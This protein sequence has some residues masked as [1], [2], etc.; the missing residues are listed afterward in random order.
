M[1]AAD[2]DQ[3]A[4]A[5]ELRRAGHHREAAEAYRAALGTGE[6]PDADAALR[7]ARCLL[8]CDDTEGAWPWVRAAVRHDER[9]RTWQAAARLLPRI[10]ALTPPPARATVRLAVLGSY[11]TAQ[12]VPLLELAGRALGVAVEAYE[13]PYGQYRQE[14]LDPG[15]GLYRFQPDVVVL[16][17]HEGD[18]ELPALSEDPE[19]DVEAEAARWVGL[20]DTLREHTGA[21]LVHHLFARRTEGPLGH[22]AARTPGSRD[23]MLQALNARLGDAA[24]DAVRL[25]DCDRLAADLGKR[26]WFDDRYWHLAKQAVSLDAL[27][28]LARHTMAVVA[29]SLGLGAKVLVLDLDDTLWGGVVGDDGVTGLR[30]GPDAGPEGEAFVAFQGLL[31]SLSHRGLLLAVCSKND[32]AVAREPFE[33]HPHMRLGLDDLVAFEA[34]WAPKAESIRRIAEQ[35]SLGLDAFVLVDDNPAEREALRQMLPEVDVVPLPAD[36]AGYARAVADHPRL[37]PD[38]LTGE[39]TRRTSQYRARAEAASLAERSG[40]LEEFLASLDM[41]ADVL[42]FDEANLARVAQ[43]VG[44]TNQFNLTTRRHDRTALERFAADPACEA[45]ALSLR[46]RLA[47][48]GLVSVVVAVADGDDLRVDTWLMSCRVIGRTLE[49]VALDELCTRAR[50]RGCRRLLG[51]YLPT[52]RNGMVADLYERLG[53]RLASR[54]ADGAADWALDLDGEAP[55]GSRFITVH[56]P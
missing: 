26:R 11:T 33:R 16:A 52:D 35:L 48:H 20:W 47:D 39:D 21:R 38:A 51:T 15:S 55:R 17:V 4:R 42:A 5:D 40:S 34:G 14:A 22:L 37:E 36:P 13:C 49:E 9:F 50:R 25:V 31:R 45:F 43:L 54:G 18:V 8:E 32:P 3:L 6:Q 28:L 46:D 19:R 12:L 23:R 41:H 27:P 1:T 2:P 7:L 44:K 24:G 53:F 10:A 29:S 30:L 56:R